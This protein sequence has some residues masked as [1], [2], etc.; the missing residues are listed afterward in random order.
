MCVYIQG[1]VKE[2]GAVT[3]YIDKG[4]QI[5]HELT[6]LEVYIQRERSHDVM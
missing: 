3:E 1:V 2:G 6:E 4:R 5:K